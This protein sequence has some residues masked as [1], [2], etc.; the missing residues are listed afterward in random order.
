MTPLITLVL[1]I[2]IVC[3]I[4]WGALYVFNLFFTPT[5]APLLKLKQ[6]VNVV[7]WICVLVWILLRIVAF[8]TGA[9]VSIG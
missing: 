6:V 7:V 9:H 3:L 1:T 8:A 4:T 5:E 2:L